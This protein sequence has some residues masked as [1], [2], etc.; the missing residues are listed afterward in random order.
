M[1]KLTQR[2]ID[3][4]LATATSRVILRDSEVQCFAVRISPDSASY[5]VECKFN[6]K[7]KRVT[8]GRTSLMTLEQARQRARE[9][10]L[11]IKSGVDPAAEKKIQK[12]ANITLREIL[13]VYLATKQLRPG[14]IDLYRR[15][16][17]HA[18]KD[19]LDLPIVKISKDM[20]EDK[21]RAMA[22]GSCRGGTSGR[23][24]ANSAFKLL[25]ALLNFVDE[26]YSVDG[27][28]LIPVNPVSRLTKTRAWYRVHQENGIESTRER[29]WYPSTKSEIGIGRCDSSRRQ[30]YRITSCYCYLPDCG[31]K[32]A[33]AEVD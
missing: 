28:P 10:L 3:T 6:G 30:P 29:A 11:T 22:N 27:Q 2:M 25:Q 18:F 32:N 15:Q 12:H 7:T 26:K 17:N 8:L 19:W 31:A 23:A 5:I 13:Q 4:T 20:V 14:T 16:C 9:V 24:Y 21:H 33:D 1:P